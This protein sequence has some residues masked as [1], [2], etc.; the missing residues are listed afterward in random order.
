MKYISLHK[1]GTLTKHLIYR[2]AQVVR[3]LPL[4]RDLL[5]LNA[6]P[7]K[8]S[9]RYQRLAT[10]ATLM[11]GPCRKAAEIG[12]AHS[13]ISHI[14]IQMPMLILA[15]VHEIRRQAEG[16]GVSY[17]SHYIYNDYGPILL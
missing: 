1:Y 10:V 15:A 16:G 12:T 5:G 7:I 6:E 4:V 3:R 14:S 13:Y 2:M 17:L 8:Y 9:T 11:C